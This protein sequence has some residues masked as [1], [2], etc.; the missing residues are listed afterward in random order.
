MTEVHCCNFMEQ[1]YHW[2][3]YR[4]KT[5]WSFSLY[6]IKLLLKM[7]DWKEQEPETELS[8][9]HLKHSIVHFKACCNLFWYGLKPAFL[10]PHTLVDPLI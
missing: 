1:I 4:K 9:K 3:E 8:I 7:I 2:F 6:L 5:C 10:I